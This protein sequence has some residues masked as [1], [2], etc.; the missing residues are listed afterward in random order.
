MTSATLV[1][2]VQDVETRA[3]QLVSSFDPIRFLL[4]LLSIPFIVVG[5]VA[6]L[7]Y[8]VVLVVAM[9]IWAAAETGWKR[10]SP[11]ASP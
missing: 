9:W 4:I 10:A 1:T 7:V 3:N 6:R 8:R 2:T 5:W 11:K